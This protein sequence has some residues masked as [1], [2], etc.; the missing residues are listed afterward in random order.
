[1]IRICKEFEDTAVYSDESDAEEHIG[2][3]MDRA[4]TSAEQSQDQTQSEDVILEEKPIETNVIKS[5]ELLREPIAMLQPI[6]PIRR[7]SIEPSVDSKGNR[8]DKKVRYSE[9]TI[10]FAS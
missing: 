5:Q 7:G 10:I 3:R 2:W 6:P 4:D 8:I 1:M 9:I